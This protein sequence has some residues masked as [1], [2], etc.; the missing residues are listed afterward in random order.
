M[1]ALG[2]SLMRCHAI[3]ALANSPR[4]LKIF[5]FKVFEHSEENSRN[6]GHGSCRGSCRGGVCGYHSAFSSEDKFKQVSFV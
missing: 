4:G 2:A 6:G 1:R 5:N 3:L